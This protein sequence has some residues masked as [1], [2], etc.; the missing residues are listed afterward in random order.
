LFI[1]IAALAI[2]AT[3]CGGSSKDA[4]EAESTPT[5]NATDLPAATTPGNEPTSTNGLPTVTLETSK[6]DVVIEMDTKNAPKAAGRF[7][8]LVGDGFY[9]GL[10]FHRVI[11]DFMI[12]GGDPDG[13]GS[14]GTDES[15]VGETPTD[16]Y[17]IGSLA[18]AKTATDPD[19]TFDCQFFITTGVNG[20]NLPPQYARF[21]T[22]ISGIEVANEIQNV[23]RDANDAPIEKVTI[24]KATVS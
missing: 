8:E 5:T 19:G 17:P 14:G 20:E 16:G 24:N 7:I 9:D 21:G 22:V 3:A 11:P 18:A 4:V 13:N 12:Q 23:E 2:V 1:V 15:V 6:G 10:T